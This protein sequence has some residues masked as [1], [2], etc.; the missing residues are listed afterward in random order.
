M[1]TWFWTVVVAN[2][3]S[4]G[5]SS[6]YKPSGALCLRFPTLYAGANR[7]AAFEAGFCEEVT[8]HNT[9]LG[10]IRAG[11]RRVNTLRSELAAFVAPTPCAIA[12]DLW[13]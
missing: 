6:T 4:L 3:L 11:I 7:A 10:D 1:Y 12:L 13:L 5:A 8:G 9:L 2:Q